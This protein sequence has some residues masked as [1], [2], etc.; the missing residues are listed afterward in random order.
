MD[1]GS[2]IFLSKGGVFPEFLETLFAILSHKNIIG[3]GHSFTLLLYAQRSSRF[4]FRSFH[5]T[6]DVRLQ[7]RGYAAAAACDC[8]FLGLLI[9]A[10][11]YR[12]I[13]RMD[14]HFA[15][16]YAYK[17][18]IS[19]SRI[20]RTGTADV[21]FRYDGSP[22]QRPPLFFGH[23]RSWPKPEG[24]LIRIGF[25]FERN[26][27]RYFFSR[28]FFL[29]QFYINV[30]VTDEFVFLFLFTSAIL[31][32]MSFPVIKITSIYDR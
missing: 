31:G 27:E 12:I 14:D 28:Y 13:F 9:S 23:G 3:T 8:Y 11:C 29:H 10:R 24:P 16:Y 6:T 17:N 1:H 5:R 4:P 18:K 30:T 7:T 2:P 26:Y 25:Q 32:G 15:W 22:F 19:R 21:G 20:R